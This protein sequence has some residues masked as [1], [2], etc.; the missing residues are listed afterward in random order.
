M[1]FE[2][3][4]ET[5]EYR[6]VCTYPGHWRV[7]QASLYVIPEGEPLPE[8]VVAPV[9]KFVQMWSTAELAAEAD[10]LTRR[11]FDAGRSTFETA[12]CIKC[13]KMK[14]SGTPLGPDLTKVAERFRG[15][16]L[17]QQ[18]LEPSTEVNKQYQTWV[19]ALSD[20]RVIS[21]LMLEQSATDLI[22]LPN[23]LKPEAKI[24]LQRSDIEELE[25]SSIS[26]MP[27]S[28]LITFSRDEILDLVAYLQ[29]GGDSGNAV[30]S[31][32]R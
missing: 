8:I 18:I 21:G 27:T 3:P 14:D 32:E 13:H 5:G 25:A 30:F 20:G 29:A 15:Q 17:L 26:T 12:G 2:A 22:L 9:R 19:A 31:S 6:L 11:S 16:K 28:L 1:F 10:S 24:T 23:P 7:M 4:K